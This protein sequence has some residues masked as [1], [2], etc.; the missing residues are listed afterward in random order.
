M[1]N[2]L[3][4]RLA[5]LKAQ[6]RAQMAARTAESPLPPV[7]RARGAN[8]NALVP[9]DAP[10]I[11]LP[12]ST[13]C[14]V[15][16]PQTVTEGAELRRSDGFGASV[17]SYRKLGSIQASTLAQ[18]RER[19]RIDRHLL[20]GGTCA[21]VEEQDD[22]GADYGCFSD[23]LAFSCTPVDPGWG[24][25]AD[26]QYRTRTRD[27]KQAQ[28]GVNKRLDPNGAATAPTRPQTTQAAVSSIS[29][30]LVAARS[31]ETTA[32]QLHPG[33]PTL[34][35]APQQPRRSS[36]S[37]RV[38]SS[39]SAV[40]EHLLNG[41]HRGHNTDSDDDD[42]DKAQWEAAFKAAEMSHPKLLAQ[43]PRYDDFGGHVMPLAPPHHSNFELRTHFWASMRDFRPGGAAPSL[44]GSSPYLQLLDQYRIQ[45]D[46]SAILP[47]PVLLRA[48]LCPQLALAAYHMGDSSAVCLARAMRSLKH[49]SRGL[50]LKM[51]DVSDNSL[52][53]RGLTALL[54][55]L[56]HRA[57]LK[58]V[59][60]SHNPP[61]A[62]EGSNR[63]VVATAV[64][65]MLRSCPNLTHLR[66]GEN[67]IG[68]TAANRIFEAVGQHKR[69]THL[70]S[71]G[72]GIALL[73]CKSLA[74]TG[75]STL[76]WLDLSYNL[77]GTEESIALAPLIQ[78]H[79]ALRSLNLS[80]NAIDDQGFGM[81]AHGFRENSSLQHVNLARNR[82]SELSA[83]ML[84][85]F[86]V[87]TPKLTSVILDGNPVGQLGG[88][89]IMSAYAQVP[90][91]QISFASCSFAEGPG[92]EPCCD[93]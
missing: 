3:E 1:R 46:A 18:E 69:L 55:L 59:D 34:L 17:R 14:P 47:L 6:C 52:H 74:C 86:L 40:G 93:C 49:M 65:K 89:M 36:S 22:Q 28:A 19:Q 39:A 23:L 15:T 45:C 7:Q 68:D 32:A 12:L 54:E 42:S 31:S 27:I 63:F 25:I 81:L 8:Y 91:K 70:D 60:I 84:R 41:L 80:W 72:N 90:S 9:A 67:S 26:M 57:E 71:S 64:T 13:A 61:D 73:C 50:Q 21:K 11:R 35:Q 76:E 20:P 82:I 44:D 78:T 58:Q 88:N 38:R 2:P 77:L 62:D 56:D 79:K 83:L 16:R 75:A 29:P 48:Q 87:G 53:Q 85:D 33:S 4:E 43:T 51:V 37:A 66:L 5:A 92:C 24:S 10:W 30:H